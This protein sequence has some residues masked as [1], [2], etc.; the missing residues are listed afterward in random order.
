MSTIFVGVFSSGGGG[1]LISLHISFGWVKIMLHTK[2]HDAMTIP[3]V[4]IWV[5]VLVFVVLVIVLVVMRK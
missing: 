4:R 3:S 2:F 1:T 5:R